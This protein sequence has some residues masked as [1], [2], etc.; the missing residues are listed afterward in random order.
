[1]ETPSQII[2]IFGFF[3]L[4]ASSALI[5]VR[6]MQVYIGGKAHRLRI[7]LEFLAFLTVAYLFAAPA[8]LLV[9]IEQTGRDIE[10]AM[11]FV[12]WVCL[13]FVINTVLRWHST[14]SR[15]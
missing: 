4:L 12:W 14:R 5:F 3:A 8:A 7:G 1:M 13:A 2:Q 6:F 9:G 10:S 15:S 11:A